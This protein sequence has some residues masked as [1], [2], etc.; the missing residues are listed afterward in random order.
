MMIPPMTPRIFLT[1]LFFAT[2]HAWGNDRPNILWITSEDNASHWLGCYGNGEAR[3]PRL[4]ALASQGLRFTSAFA[5]GPVCAVARSTILNGA[6]AVT[7]GTQHMRS[8][9]AIPSAYKSYVSYLREQGYHCTNNS[10]TDYNFKGNDP[11]IWDDCSGRATYQ[12]RPDHKPFFAVFNLTVSH[13]S[14]LFPQNIEANRK[15]GIIPATPRVDPAAINVPPYLPDLP[16]IRSD[17]AIYHDTITALDTQV[18]RLLDELDQSGLADNTIVFYFGDHGGI[19]PRGKR[20]LEDTGARVPMLIRIPEKWRA[21]CPFPAGKPVNEVVSFVDLAPTLLSLVDL[22]KPAQMQGRAFLGVK[23]SEPPPDAMAFLYADRF[24]ELQG[25]R[26]GLTN[27]RWKY[28]RRFS[29][30]LPAAPYSYYQFGQSAWNAWKKAWQ[31]GKLSGR[32]KEI[33][34]APQPVEELFD[35]QNDPWEINNLAADPVHRSRLE[36]M[37]SRLRDTMIATR[38]SSLIPEAMYAELSAGN[39]IASYWLARS[40]DLPALVDLAFTASSRDPHQIA[41]LQKELA[42]T[43]PV[44]RYWAAQGCLIL[45]KDAVPATDSLVKLLNDPNSAVR[46]A[47]AHA[48]ATLDHRDRAVT[49]LVAE[50]EDATNEEAGL[51]AINAL[52]HLDALSAIPKTWAKRIIADKKSSE[53]LRRTAEDSVK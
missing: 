15:R 49:A 7:Q 17:I 18:G 4:D 2:H 25:M 35:T 33:W 6:H 11:A 40:A 53:Y 31:S 12:N 43:D 5:N 21:L 42:S 45:G 39:P 37:R 44:S 24:D 46:V 52:T 10:K 34:E 3:T 26:R 50:L 1:F 22:E 48:L 19:L 9:H 32:H 20:Y 36:T 28:I 16:E 14:S 38:D 51:N 47:A 23:R 13:E 30:H 27:G 8:R 29:P 41:R